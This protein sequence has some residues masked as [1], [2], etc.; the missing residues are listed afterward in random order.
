MNGLRMKL[1]HSSS[2]PSTS[3]RTTEDIFVHVFLWYC[4]AFLV[5]EYTSPG[6]GKKMLTKRT[7]STFSD[8]WM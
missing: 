8:Q 1:D 3:F 4:F 2:F 5:G 7:A 6:I